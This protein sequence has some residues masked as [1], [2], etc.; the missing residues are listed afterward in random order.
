MVSLSAQIMC[1]TWSGRFVCPVIYMSDA[2]LDFHAAGPRSPPGPSEAL[3]RRHL[4]RC[5]GLPE[6][7]IHSLVKG[8]RPDDHDMMVQLQSAA[9]EPSNPDVKTTHM[10]YHE[11]MASKRR[12]HELPPI[13][14]DLEAVAPGG[15]S[16]TL[17][18]L[19][20]F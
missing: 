14:V 12:R 17:R 20:A 9:P 19:S 8:S 4:G 16:E 2:V 1:L 15:A 6:T 13:F 10:K 5:P 11:V 18:S 3:L 7:P